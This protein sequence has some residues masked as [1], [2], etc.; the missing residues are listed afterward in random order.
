MYFHQ[1]NTAGSSVRNRMYNKVEKNTPD[2]SK[3]SFVMADLLT[4]AL[5]QCCVLC[6]MRY[7]S[8][9]SQTKGAFEKAEE[10]REATGDAAVQRFLQ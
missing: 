3:M 6:R 7:F 2:K 8:P 10:S 1:L 4:T 5:N 9:M